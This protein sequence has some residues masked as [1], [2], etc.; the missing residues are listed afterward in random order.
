MPVL[1]V[2]LLALLGACEDEP[3]TSPSAPVRSPEPERERFA[4]ELSRE[5]LED[6]AR[7]GRPPPHAILPNGQ[8]LFGVEPSVEFLMPLN[9]LIS[10]PSRHARRAIKTEGRVERVERDMGRTFDLI[11]PAT[12]ALLHVVI[13]DQAFF[14]PR[15]AAGVHALVQGTLE[16]SV[17]EVPEPV[18]GEEPAAAPVTVELHATG[19]VLD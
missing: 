17:G 10:A 8:R 6:L 18:E 5:E 19:V 2:T 12:N 13:T 3:V 1:G 7:D 9:R 11:D 14:V 4:Y 16:V 15:D